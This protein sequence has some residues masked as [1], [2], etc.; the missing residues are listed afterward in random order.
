MARQPL[1]QAFGCGLRTYFAYGKRVIA[2]DGGVSHAKIGDC[3]I[4][5]LAAK[6]MTLQEL[7]EGRAAAVEVIDRMVPRE[8]LDAENRQ[9]SAPPSNTLGDCRNARRRG[10]SRGSASSAVMKA[11]HFSASRPK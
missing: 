7:V 2:D 10:N 5:L 8:F 11:S 4:R 6:R 1:G 3:R 9:S